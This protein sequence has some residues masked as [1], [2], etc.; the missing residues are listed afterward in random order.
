MCV[1]VPLFMPTVAILASSGLVSTRP[2]R[3]GELFLDN[4]D[5]ASQPVPIDLRALKNSAV[6]HAR[7][8][9]NPLLDKVTTEFRHSKGV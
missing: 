6:R 5:Q 8:A 7:D 4:F 2:V 9:K 1:N 3:F